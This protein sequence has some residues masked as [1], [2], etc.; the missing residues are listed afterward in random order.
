MSDKAIPLENGQCAVFKT[1]E[2][3]EELVRLKAAS[4][5][6]KFIIL[7]GKPLNEPIIWNG[8][9]IL[10]TQE[11]LKQAYQDVKQG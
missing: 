9:F 1:S 11:Q 7:S 4:A 3:Q 5:T 10:N 6:A 2:K 8:P